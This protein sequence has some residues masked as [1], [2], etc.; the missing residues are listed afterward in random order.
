MATPRSLL[1]AEERTPLPSGFEEMACVKPL[2][3]F[4][5][6]CAFGAELSEPEQCYTDHAEPV[7]KL[8]ALDA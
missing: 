6:D 3:L 5:Y 1:T 8:S 2:D 4:K 7:K